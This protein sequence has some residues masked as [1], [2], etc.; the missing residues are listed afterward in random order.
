MMRQAWLEVSSRALVHNLNALRKIVVGDARFMSVIK[1]NAYGH[2]AVE[3]ARILQ[4]NGVAYFGVATLQEGLALRENGVGGEILI[5]G[6]TSPEDIAAA[7]KHNLTQ[8]VYSFAQAE[9]IDQCAH[10]GDTPAKVHL[11]IDTGL[12]RTGYL[13][14]QTAVSE[15]QKI[16]RLPNLKI[17]GIYSHFAVADSLDSSYTLEQFARFQKVLGDLERNGIEIPL[18]HI[19][20][21]AAIINYPATH[22]DLVRAGIAQYGYY[23]D[24]AMAR[25][26]KIQLRPAMTVRTRLVQ[27]KKVAPG[28]SIGYGCTFTSATPM[29]IGTIPV[30]YGDGY[31]R[32]LSNRGE[33]LIGGRRRPIVGRI[34]MDQFM[35]DVSRPPVP[36]VGDEVVVMGTQGEEAVTADEIA[37]MDNTISYEILCRLGLRLP[38]IH[39]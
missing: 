16:T 4:R 11:K 3:V 12:G 13:P 8:T 20:N 30:G 29:I 35:A 21:S 19:A 28:S 18:K 14:N 15:I 2:G 26:D 7:L 10:S 39:R 37:A 1:A 31:P 6:R 38:R 36:E 17:A 32:S 33:V 34:C 23:P 22:L 5:F 9:A 27:V 25:E 24:A